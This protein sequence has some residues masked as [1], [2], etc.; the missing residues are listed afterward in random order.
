MVH[1]GKRSEKARIMRSLKQAWREQGKPE[2]EHIVDFVTMEIDLR[3]GVEELNLPPGTVLRQGAQRLDVETIIQTVYQQKCEELGLNTMNRLDV[4]SYE[5]VNM[6]TGS[7]QMTPF[8][9]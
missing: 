6:C 9:V 3:S 2:K 5:V 1:R 4:Y 7:M 8:G